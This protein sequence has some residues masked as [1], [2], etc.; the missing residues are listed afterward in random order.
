M[1]QAITLPLL[2]FIVV[3]IVDTV[4]SRNVFIDVKTPWPRYTT[5]FIA[6]I[7]EFLFEQ[8]PHDFWTY[9]DAVCLH[10]KVVDDAILTGSQ[11]SAADLQS[12][13]FELGTTIAPQ[14]MHSLMDTLLGLGAYAP[15]V[16]FYEAMSETLGDPCD[17]GS[18]VYVGS[19]VICDI[20]SLKSLVTKAETH[21][22]KTHSNEAWDH[23]YPG[24]EA[25]LSSVPAILY[26]SLGTSSFC[27]FHEVLKDLAKAGKIRYSFRH[28]FP[29]MKAIANTT[30]IQGF[31]VFLDIKNME[32]KNVDDKDKDDATTS[33]SAEKATVR[34]RRCRYF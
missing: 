6:E 2:L 31:G 23:I 19:D 3:S 5:T 9:T 12:I 1:A 18:F 4:V 29:G 26:G 21:A 13:S 10:S 14:P 27:T 8:S 33:T 15:A 11:D 17:G 24:S 30:S 16:R 34:L 7:S 22:S 25:F 20:S 28:A 32:Y